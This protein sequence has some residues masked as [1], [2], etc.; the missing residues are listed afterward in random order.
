MSLKK[1]KVEINK[2]WVHYQQFWTAV[3]SARLFQKDSV[4]VD[5]EEIQ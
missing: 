5:S 4:E 3:K 2:L 1:I